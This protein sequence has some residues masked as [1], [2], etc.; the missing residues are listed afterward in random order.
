MTPPPDRRV[1]EESLV[2]ERAACGELL[3]G[4]PR[5]TEDDVRG[6]VEAPLPVQYPPLGLEA[7][8]LQP[9]DR[10]GEDV[11]A[12]V[13]EADENARATRECHLPHEGRVVG[14]VDGDRR[15]P[16]PLD[17]LESPTEAA[18]VLPV[19][20]RVVVEEDGAGLARREPL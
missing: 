4:H 8:L 18:Q 15:A 10:P 12:V 2:A 19:G 1:R 20:A 16:D 13:V 17:R 7:V 14:D 9:R 3:L 11:G 5:G 6:V